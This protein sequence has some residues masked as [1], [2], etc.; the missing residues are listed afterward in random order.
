MS[1]GYTGTARR[2]ISIRDY[3]ASE[4]ELSEITHP[5]PTCGKLA[6]LDTF[7]VSGKL[8]GILRCPTF[9][10]SKLQR[11]CKGCPP[12]RLK[13]EELEKIMAFTKEKKPRLTAEER[14]EIHTG[15]QACGLTINKLNDLAGMSRARLDN[16]LKNKCALS[17][18]EMG[19]IR[20]VLK[21]KRAEIERA[22]AKFER[23]N[24]GKPHKEVPVLVQLESQAKID[25]L[26][27]LVQELSGRVGALEKSEA[28]LLSQE[29]RFITSAKSPDLDQKFQG[30]EYLCTKMHKLSPELFDQAI[31]RARQTVA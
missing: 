5:C 15:I 21:E 12:L 11:L 18:D 8:E 24:P 28:F 3:G 27:R 22:A 9:R 4:V 6:S 20:D 25:R 19:R 29:Q 1:A 26:E 31:H 23:Q 14:Q 16:A 10:R 17:P 7:E 30:F 13:N 2:G